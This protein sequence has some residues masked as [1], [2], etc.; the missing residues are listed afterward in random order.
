MHKKSKRDRPVAD[1]ARD[2]VED[3]GAGVP[4]IRRLA[5]NEDM[6]AGYAAGVAAAGESNRP[7]G[8]HAAPEYPTDD[9]P[10][11]IDVDA[12]YSLDGEVVEPGPG[13][14]LDDLDE[15]PEDPLPFAER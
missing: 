14:H 4:Y 13:E 9:P 6:D 12:I 15:R 1:L 11:E 5:R 7:A 3:L 2:A 10:T 8:T